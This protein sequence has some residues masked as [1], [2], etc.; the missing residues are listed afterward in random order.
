[1]KRVIVIGSPG[2]GKSTFSARLG[3]VSGLPVYHLDMMFWNEDKT[4]VG[5]EVFFERLSSVLSMDEWIID[6]NYSS[7]MELR[8]DASDTVFFLDYPAELCLE[9]VRQRIGKPRPDMPWVE[10]SED[11]EFMEFIKRFGERER[12]RITELLS[13]HSEKTVFVFKSREDA[14]AFLSRARL[15]RL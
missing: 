6:G 2:A 13:A 5:R 15:G 7:T 1:M 3:E 12:P 9:G 11:G 8:L 14:D 10:E 4:T